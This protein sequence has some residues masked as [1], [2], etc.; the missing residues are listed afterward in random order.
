MKLDYPEDTSIG[1][2][3]ARRPAAKEETVDED[4]EFEDFL[5]VDDDDD[6]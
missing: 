1:S 5:P 3:A 6:D 4:P 2:F